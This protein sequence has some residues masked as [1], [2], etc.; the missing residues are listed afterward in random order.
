MIKE[1]LML[2]AILTLFLITRLTGIAQIPPSLYWDEASI[3][4]N[5]YA[6]LTTGRD[7][8]GEVLP[9]HFR[10]FGEFKLPVYI[11]TVAA[12][13]SLLG[14]SE[15][16][17]RLPAVLFSLVTV[18]VTFLLGIKVTGQRSV[19]LMAAL[20][21]VTLPWF[22]LISRAGFEASAGLALFLLGIYLF[23]ISD[24]RSSLIILATFALIGSIYSYNSFRVIALPVFLGLLVLSLFKQR[25]TNNRTHLWLLISMLL[26][27]VS[28]VPI[29]RLILVDAGAAR[30]AA[31]GIFSH[32]SNLLNSLIDFSLNYL[33]HFSWDFLVQTGDGNLRHGVGG[34]GVMLMFQ[35]IL[36]ALGIA[37]LF[38]H[39]RQKLIWLIPTIILLVLIPSAITTEAPH[40]LRSIAA[41]PFVAMLAAGGVSWLVERLRMTWLY[42]V[43]VVLILLFFGQFLTKFF[44]VYP[45]QAARDW[46][47]GYKQVFTK[48]QSE[49]SKYDS[50]VISD[51]DAQ[52]YIFGL[53]YLQYDPV[54][55]RQ[56][57]QYNPV[58]RWGVSTV[59]SF[60]KFVFM[61][62]QLDNLP[63]G[64]LL[65]FATKQE[66]LTGQMPIVSLNYFDVYE[67]KNR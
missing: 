13:E 66:K 29:I 20:I 15:L 16:A 52:P 57:V 46:Q 50:V 51:Q 55:F 19:G 9:L 42:L 14:M 67:Y 38:Q 35:L 22:F 56:S 45:Q 8:W 61:P 7:E 36:T 54:K 26:M 58:D 24:K 32:Y 33:A 48:Y 43:A 17:V 47:Y 25:G 6:V 53:F 62:I 63:K 3:G 28:W 1:K 41:A 10:A 60:D 4:Y 49:F 27:V 39:R 65:I 34:F 12:F 2:V 64:R 37:W 23:L 18:L 44:L 31:V 30:L 11:Y 40:N 59:K 5:A 21:L